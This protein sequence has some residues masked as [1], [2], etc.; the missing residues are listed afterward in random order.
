MYPDKLFFK[1][2]L[3][4]AER[5]GMVSLVN[6][7]ASNSSIASTYSSID[8]IVGM[9]FHGAVLA[10]MSNTPFV[11]FACDNKMSS[12]CN[13]FLMPY[14]DVDS[15]LPEW[16]VRAANAAIEVD[17]DEEK[18]GSLSLLSGKNYNFLADQDA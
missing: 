18:L 12:I 7:V 1:A 17:I 11:G 5:P 6:V 14:L 4:A 8:I 13:E 16:L 9:R 3:T 10:S 15:V 2:V